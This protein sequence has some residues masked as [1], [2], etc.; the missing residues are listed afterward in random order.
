[1]PVDES[2]SDKSNLS[3]EDTTPTQRNQYSVSIFSNQSMVITALLFFSWRIPG[4][5]GN[6][7]QLLTIQADELK[8]KVYKP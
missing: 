5:D 8:C 6:D 7:P 4:L 2:N 3:A 1:M